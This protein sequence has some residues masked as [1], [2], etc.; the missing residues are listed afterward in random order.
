MKGFL[1]F[2]LDILML[3]KQDK[4][5]IGLSRLSAQEIDIRQVTKIT[6]KK[7]EVRL[8]DLMRKAS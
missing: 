5:Y 6:S 7:Q 1:D 3:K 2:I 8:S 4:K